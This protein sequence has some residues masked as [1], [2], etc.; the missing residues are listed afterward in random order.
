VVD[1]VGVEVEEEEGA[2]ARARALAVVLAVLA[3]LLLL[4]GREARA[5]RAASVEAGGR[6]LVLG[7]AV[8]AKMLVWRVV[9]A[10]GRGVVM[11][12][13]E[14]VEVEVAEADE[15]VGF[16]KTELLLLVVAGRAGRAVRDELDVEW[17]VEIVEKEREEEE[18]DVAARRVDEREEVD[19]ALIDATEVEV[20]TRILETCEVVKTP[21][22]DCEDSVVWTWVSVVGAEVTLEVTPVD[23]VADGCFRQNLALKFLG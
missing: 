10:E 1:V 5:A 22:A 6:M 16:G 19:I 23:D 17:V 4:G 14:E 21:A 7:S 20:E 15:E 2:R 18:M 11:G 8:V 13:A 12:S 3:V 9:A